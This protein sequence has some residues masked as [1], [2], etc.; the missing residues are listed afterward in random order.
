MSYA[1]EFSSSPPQTDVAQGNWLNTRK[2]GRDDDDITSAA[3]TA[4]TASTEK[5]RRR[6]RKT[7]ESDIG[8]VGGV[9]GTRPP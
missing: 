7:P 6:A 4:K 2:Q 1:H 5:R 8:D 9:L 3:E